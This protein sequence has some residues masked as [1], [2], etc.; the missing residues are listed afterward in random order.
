MNTVNI[1]LKSKK[2]HSPEPIFRKIQQ[3]DRTVAENEDLAAVLQEGNIPEAKHG[4]WRH[5]HGG[6]KAEDANLD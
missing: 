4:R 6:L 3:A 5:H 1:M 2:R